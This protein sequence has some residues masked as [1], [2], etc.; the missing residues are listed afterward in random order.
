MTQWSGKFLMMK[1]YFEI[2]V[3]CTQLDDDEVDVLT[4]GDNKRKTLAKHIKLL[5]VCGHCTVA[6]QKGKLSLGQGQKVV[7]N[8]LRNVKNRVAMLNYLEDD[9]NILVGFCALILE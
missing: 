1:R 9:G 5:L 7:E 2:W 8:L 4:L 6:L 3:F